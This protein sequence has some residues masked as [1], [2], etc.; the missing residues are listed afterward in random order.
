MRSFADRMTPTVAVPGR[1][2]R[3]STRYSTGTTSP[4]AVFAGHEMRTGAKSGPGALRMVRGAPALVLSS[5]VAGTSPRVLSGS[6]TTPR[7]HVPRAASPGSVTVTGMVEVRP[8]AGRVTATVPSAL[9]KT[10]MRESVE[11]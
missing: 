1:T 3:F 10:V 9:S 11:R 6:T 2:P 8:G 5:I 4:A 7:L